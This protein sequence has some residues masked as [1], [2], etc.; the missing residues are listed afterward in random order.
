MIYANPLTS[1]FDIFHKAFLGVGYVNTYALGYSCGF[2]VIV[3]ILGLYVFHRVERTFM[4]T[5]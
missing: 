3:Y 4:D 1:V 5:I 2:A